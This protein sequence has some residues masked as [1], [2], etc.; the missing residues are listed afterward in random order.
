MWCSSVALTMH[1]SP[2]V[3][4]SFLAHSR[5]AHGAI[6]R[7]GM[8]CGV[9]LARR[10]TT[11]PSTTFRSLTS[12]GCKRTLLLLAKSSQTGTSI[13]SS[14]SLCPPSARVADQRRVRSVRRCYTRSCEPLYT[15]AD[16]LHPHYLCTHTHAVCAPLLHTLV[17]A[18]VHSCKLCTLIQTFY[19][20]VTFAHS[21]GRYVAATH[22]RVSPPLTLVQPFYT[23]ATVSYPCHSAQMTC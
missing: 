17:R 13:L 20:R 10:T 1:L 8:Y 5:L 11:H 6:A 23:R 15:H 16:L 2:A 12:R 21:C 22:A 7:P 19:T 14:T 3:P 9:R 18:L 4:I